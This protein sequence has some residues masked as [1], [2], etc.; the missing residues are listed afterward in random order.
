MNKD[1]KKV[2]AALDEQGFT[3]KTTKRGHVLV[4]KDGRAVTT[5]AGTPSDRRSW[6][7]G[8]SHLKRAGFIWPPK[9]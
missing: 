3:V 5:L 8:L 4:L 9:K 2:L 1:L 7:N 6:L